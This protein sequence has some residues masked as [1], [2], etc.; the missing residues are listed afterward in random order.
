MYADLL[1]AETAD[2]MVDRLPNLELETIANR[3]HVPTLEEPASL[4]VIEA[5]VAKVDT[6]D[7]QSS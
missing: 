2:K 6:L 1:S 3:G 5:F 4:S 7:R